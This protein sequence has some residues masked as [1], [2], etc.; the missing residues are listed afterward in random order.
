MSELP[1]GGPEAAEVVNPVDDRSPT[2]ESVSLGAID[3]V[4]AFTALR[5][6]LKLQIRSGRE[7]QQSLGSAMNRMEQM[8]TQQPKTAVPAPIP[9]DSRR[10]AEALAEMEESIQRV[11]ESLA[12]Q[13]AEFSAQLSAR[14]AGPT[15]ESPEELMQKAP[16]SVRLFAKAFSKK[17]GGLIDLH[18][19]MRRHSE[20]RRETT[21]QVLTLLLQRVRRLM[22]QC[23]LQRVDVLHQPFDAESMHAVD[24]VDS[25]S[26]PKAH[27]AEQI[28]P[29][30]LWRGRVLRYADVRLAR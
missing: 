17:L 30:Y 15:S 3:I 25:P 1:L 4:E 10:L 8:V 27:V 23:D 20:V 29:A 11:I 24:L 26:T 2:L 9:D 21:S 6:E 19:A 28:R 5:H 22:Q 18:V 13:E 7:L 12:Q 16:W 14:Q